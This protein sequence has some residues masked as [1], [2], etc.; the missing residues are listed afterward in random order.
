MALIGKVKKY[1]TKKKYI[2]TRID[3]RYHYGYVF[4]FCIWKENSD[5]PNRHLLR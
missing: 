1:E 3:C 5:N 2:R 4:L